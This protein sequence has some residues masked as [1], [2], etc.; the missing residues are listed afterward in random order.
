MDGELGSSDVPLGFFGEVAQ[1]VA[2]A[3][4]S[5][6]AS[7][8]NSTTAIDGK[9]SEN[10]LESQIPLQ[11]SESK[12]KDTNPLFTTQSFISEHQDPS[13]AAQY[14]A[15]TDIINAP[16][17]VSTA[18]T[19]AT[20]YELVVEAV[21]EIDGGEE[22]QEEDGK[23]KKQK[24]KIPTE[25]DIATADANLLLSLEVAASRVNMGDVGRPEF[26]QV[27]EGKEGTD[28]AVA[29]A[30]EPVPATTTTA[31]TTQG[32]LIQSQ[33]PIDLPPRSRTTSRMRTRTLSNTMRPPPTV[34][35]VPPP[36]LSRSS[37]F[38]AKNAPASFLVKMQ[39]LKTLHEQILGAIDVFCD[40]TYRGYAGDDL[41][42]HGNPTRT[43]R[44]DHTA[45]DSQINSLVRELAVIR[46]ETAKIVVNNT[47]QLTQSLSDLKILHSTTSEE[48]QLLVKDVA[49]LRLKNRAL[50]AKLREVSCK[51]KDAMEVNNIEE[52]DGLTSSED[53]GEWESWCQHPFQKYHG[54]HLHLEQMEFEVLTKRKRA[55]KFQQQLRATVIAIIP[56]KM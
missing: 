54:I 33:P 26:A 17:T 49:Q 6:H 37:S 50:R 12:S 7:R 10:V 52:G 9:S 51:K 35:G 2:I 18:S 55:L 34:A 53:E 36:L 14:P 5:V 38:T 43:Q 1:T 44:T 11:L 39:Q 15:Y 41:S 19:K 22:E 29:Q 46:E 56:G 21:K 27:D 25:A 4:S 13:P 47:Q 30:N 20:F 45:C 42:E 23:K 32:N 48:Y 31:P 28:G 16:T 24:P 3:V 40:E 8:K